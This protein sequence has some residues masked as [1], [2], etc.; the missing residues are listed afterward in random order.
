MKSVSDFY[1]IEFRSYA[2]LVLDFE[3]NNVKKSELVSFKHKYNL[4]PLQK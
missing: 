2:S 1:G 4:F 3:S